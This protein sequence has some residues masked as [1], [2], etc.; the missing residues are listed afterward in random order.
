VYFITRKIINLKQIDFHHLIETILLEILKPFLEIKY[1][2]F[3]LQ[4]A[5]K[6]NKKKKKKK[7]F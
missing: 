2:N 7:K 1:E 3:R 4:I 6:L 5:M